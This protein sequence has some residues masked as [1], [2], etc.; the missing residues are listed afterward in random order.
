[1]IRK[2]THLSVLDSMLKRLSFVVTCGYVTYLFLERKSAARNAHIF[3]RSRP[4]SIG[5]SITC[6]Q[7]SQSIDNHLAKSVVHIRSATDSGNYCT[8]TK[9]EKLFSCLRPIFFI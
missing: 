6:T 4:K 7:V 1:M 5:K 3:A 2:K 8:R 9:L